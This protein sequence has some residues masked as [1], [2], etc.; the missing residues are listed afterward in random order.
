MKKWSQK[1]DYEL[2]NKVSQETA[3]EIAARIRELERVL[4][5]I[6]GKSWTAHDL[7]LLIHP[8]LPAERSFEPDTEGKS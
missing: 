6:L 1:T 2:R 3:D 7:S 8:L 4:L 5:Q